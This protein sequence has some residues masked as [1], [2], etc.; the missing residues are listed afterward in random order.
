LRGLKEVVKEADGSLVVGVE[1][2]GESVVGED[3]PTD[4]TEGDSIANQTVAKVKVTMNQVLRKGKNRKK[5]VTQMQAMK[6]KSLMRK[7]ASPQ[8]TKKQRQK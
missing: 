4:L 2:D 7:S 3:G 5:R 8:V 1:E 6:I